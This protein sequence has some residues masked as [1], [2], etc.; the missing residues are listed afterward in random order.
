MSRNPYLAASRPT[1]SFT[2]SSRTSKRNDLA[3]SKGLLLNRSRS[4]VTLSSSVANHMGATGSYGSAANYVPSSSSWQRS[5]SSTRLQRSTNDPST[6]ASSYKAS[7]YTPSNQR[8]LSPPE[9]V[10]V[11]SESPQSNQLKSS[12]LHN[13]GSSERD[14]DDNESGFSSVLSCSYRN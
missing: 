7:A 6:P 10:P 2:R 9:R 13:L 5:L 1:S 14:D 3:S 8:Q 11:T 4:S 12:S